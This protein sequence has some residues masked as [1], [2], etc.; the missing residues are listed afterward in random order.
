MW[1]PPTRNKNFDKGPP[2]PRAVK[3][4]FTMRWPRR[5]SFSLRNERGQDLPVSGPVEL[6]RVSSNSP[7]TMESDL[8]TTQLDMAEEEVGG[9]DR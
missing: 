2:A 4:S 3:V 7:R 5:T 1:Q 9:K 6:R 8:Y